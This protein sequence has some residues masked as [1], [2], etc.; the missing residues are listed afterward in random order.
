MKLETFLHISI[1][2]RTS[3]DMG[4]RSNMAFYPF[5]DMPCRSET[6]IKSG[7][8]WLLDLNINAVDEI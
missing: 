4:A 5:S 6:N 1:F 8:K 2:D 3:L 7:P